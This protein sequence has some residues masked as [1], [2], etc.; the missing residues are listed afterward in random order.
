MKTANIM[1]W[2]NIVFAVVTATLGSWIQAT[3]FLAIASMF[4]CAELIIKEI[5]YG[6]RKEGKSNETTS[7][8]ETSS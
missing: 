8:V 4:M 3:V 1:Y 6:E 7:V 2:V 5:R